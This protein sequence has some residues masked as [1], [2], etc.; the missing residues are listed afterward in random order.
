[1]KHFLLTMLVLT[2]FNC[3]TPPTRLYNPQTSII[4]EKQA[5]FGF[6]HYRA[7]EIPIFGKRAS[8]YSNFNFVEIISVNDANKTVISSPVLPEPPV[9]LKE[10]DIETLN[11]NF[12]NNNGFQTILILDPNKKY[13]IKSIR[14]MQKCGSNCR[15]EILL[16]LSLY[17]SYKTLPIHAQAGEIKYAGVFKFTDVETSNDDPDGLLVLSPDPLYN[18]IIE[19]IGNQKKQKSIV[20]SEDGTLTRS[21]F[22]DEINLLYESD[23]DLS[24]KSSRKK[25]LV[26]FLKIQKSGFWFEKAT[27][28]LEAEK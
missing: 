22:T 20:G 11:S 3:K 13:A 6:G 16:N 9:S 25:F 24:F 8:V 23:K 10:N 12:S 14:F 26:E 7:F 17:D 1:M 18:A 4:G 27:K 28:L 2:G 21:K 19:G 15:R 5:I